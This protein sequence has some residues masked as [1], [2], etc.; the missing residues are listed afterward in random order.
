MKGGRERERQKGEGSRG[1]G[2][3]GGGGGQTFFRVS[4]KSTDELS[5]NLSKV[6][7]T[8]STPVVQGA[9]FKTT[10]IRSLTIHQP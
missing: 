3:G 1:G 10:F 7:I 9:H 2:G 8:N 4:K 6:V 5:F